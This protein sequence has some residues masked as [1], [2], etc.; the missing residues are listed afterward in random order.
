MTEKA[1]AEGIILYSLAP[2][3]M[4]FKAKAGQGFEWPG[5]VEGDPAHG[6]GLELYE[7]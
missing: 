3:L 5:P 4:V 1:A 2:S 6:R 7:L